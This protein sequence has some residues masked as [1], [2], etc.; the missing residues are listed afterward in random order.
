MYP[1]LNSR[2]VLKALQSYH[3]MAST[4]SFFSQ[5]ALW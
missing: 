1:M 3:A 4:K 2:R 5:W